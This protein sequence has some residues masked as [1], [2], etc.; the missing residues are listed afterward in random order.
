M[1]CDPRVGELSTLLVELGDEAGNM[2]WPA[3]EILRSGSEVKCGRGHQ[4]VELLGRAR[5]VA[6]VARPGEDQCWAG[7]RC[8]GVSRWKVGA[9]CSPEDVGQARG[10]PA[11]KA[12]G[13]AVVVGRIGHERVRRRDRGSSRDDHVEAPL[14]DRIRSG[15]V[16]VHLSG[17]CFPARRRDDQH[18]C[19]DPI[20]G[21]GRDVEC[22]GAPHRCPACDVAVDA[23]R[24][25]ERELIVG[26]SGPRIV[27]EIG[28][29]RGVAVASS[30]VANEPS[31]D[32]GP[33]E[34]P[35]LVLELTA[36]GQ[37]VSPDERAAGP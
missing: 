10:I 33:I 7:D 34:H 37:P 36:L 6:G 15:E 23:K 18:Q 11:A 24:I 28:R 32:R 13:L 4:S 12:F 17:S 25:D 5:G 31:I 21:V 27:G 9:S 19:I 3:C 22:G 30:V 16:R 8:D 1:D 26:Q 35:G 2:I 14:I 20:G 29:R